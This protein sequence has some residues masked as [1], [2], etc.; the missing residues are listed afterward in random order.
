MRTIDEVDG[1]R[2]YAQ[3][4]ANVLYTHVNYPGKL[5]RLRKNVDSAAN[6]REVWDFIQARLKKL[7]AYMVPVELVNVTRELLEQLD[8]DLLDDEFG[9]LV[10]MVESKD[11]RKLS[12][13]TI[14]RNGNGI[15]VEFKPKWLIQSPC[16][17]KNAY[18]CRTCSIRRMRNKSGTFCPLDL[19]S[20]DPLRLAKAVKELVKD[21][22]TGLPLEALLLDYFSRSNIL[23][24]LKRLQAL[25]SRGPLGG[26]D[27]VC[28]V[29][30]EPFT[31]AM[32][33]RDVTIL[34]EV[35]NTHHV[36]ARLIDLDPKRYAGSKL[37]KLLDT[38]TKLDK[39]YYKSASQQGCNV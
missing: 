1:W 17:P 31:T 3:G 20:N 8:E 28:Y 6:A 13:A 26:D 38:E 5:L 32:T 39:W 25:D 33:S 27:L 35:S 7:H 37:A 11:Q 21:H 34:V 14:G 22:G 18:Y 30:D 24:E 36:Q 23:I 12:G 10:D 19:G 9:L 16:A 2:F 29:N 4:G 15:V